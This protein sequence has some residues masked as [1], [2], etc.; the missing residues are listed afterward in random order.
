ML[1][2]KRNLIELTFDALESPSKDE[3]YNSTS[4]SLSANRDQWIDFCKKVRPI[5][6][7]EEKSGISKI[8]TSF[9]IRENNGDYF[10]EFEPEEPNTDW[11]FCLEV[12]QVQ[13][14][15]DY[16]ESNV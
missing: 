13:E 11:T 6:L 7:G 4:V 14:L 15:I 1:V 9:E 3:L 12:A 2:N 8:G 5:V 10:V 16:I